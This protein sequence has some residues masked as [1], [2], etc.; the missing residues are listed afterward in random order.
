MSSSTIAHHWSKL[1]QLAED[2]GKLLLTMSR[3]LQDLSNRQEVESP[4]CA[5]KQSC[6]LKEKSAIRCQNNLKK[7]EADYLEEDKVCIGFQ[8][9]IIE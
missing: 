1:E 4:V 5:G 3:V 2:H 6:Y 7:A 8:L 9:L